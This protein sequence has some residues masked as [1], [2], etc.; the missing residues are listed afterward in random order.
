MLRR[1]SK[2]VRANV[3]QCV[4]KFKGALNSAGQPF[5]CKR[6]TYNVQGLLVYLRGHQDGKGATYMCTTTKL[7]TSR[8]DAVA[9]ESV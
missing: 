1:A 7:T 4:Q 3:A 2:W 8:E 5:Q 9:T 6:L